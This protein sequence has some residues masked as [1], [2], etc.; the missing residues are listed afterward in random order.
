[1]NKKLEAD[2][3]FQEAK[4]QT[5]KKKLEADHKF[6]ENLAIKARNNQ[7]EQEI[8]QEKATTRETSKILRI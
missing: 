4:F 1:M 2:H 5:M 3:K 7:E 6:Q 8:N